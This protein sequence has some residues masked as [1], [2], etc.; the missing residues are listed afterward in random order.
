MTLYMLMFA[1]NWVRVL[2]PPEGTN[3]FRIVVAWLL[4]L[5]KMPFNQLKKCL[6]AEAPSIEEES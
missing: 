3:V 6:S 2:F 1:N 4:G 5:K